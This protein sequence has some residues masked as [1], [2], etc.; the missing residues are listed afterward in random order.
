MRKL[1]TSPPRTSNC[2]I[3]S[4]TSASAKQ[5]TPRVSFVSAQTRT[6]SYLTG[7]E[8]RHSLA[9]AM[10]DRGIIGS[11]S[12]SLD[13]L[14]AALGI[15]A[16]LVSLYGEVYLPIF[17]RMESEV[18]AAKQRALSFNRAML[19]AKKRATNAQQTCNKSNIE[20]EANSVTI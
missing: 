12:Y 4:I 2:R 9:I 16:E 15:A 8:P 10:A 1:T 7:D 5:I 18:D 6:Y 14:E 19:I 20:P 3:R 11:K 13:Q 17:N